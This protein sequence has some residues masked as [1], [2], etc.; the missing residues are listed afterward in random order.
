MNEA[1][2]HI[3]QAG[4][5]WTVKLYRGAFPG[6]AEQ[7]LAS[8][9][10]LKSDLTGRGVTLAAALQAVRETEG[11]AKLFSNI[12]QR[13]F[14]V[15]EKAQVVDAWVQEK[16]AAPEGLLTYFLIDES[17][18]QWPWELLSKSRGPGLREYA[19]A[20]RRHPCVR[21]YATHIPVLPANDGTLRVLLIAGEEVLDPP[22]VK[23]CSELH[24]IQRVF[25][26]SDWSVVVH[27]AKWPATQLALEAEIRRVCPHI[28]H[29]IGHGAS[30]AEDRFA[31]KFAGWE[32]SSAA[33]DRFFAG[34]DWKPRLF[35]I[36]ACHG[37]QLDEKRAVAAVTE[38]LLTAGVP[39]V[40]GSQAT[41]RVD[42]SRN[43]A[44]A[45][46]RTLCQTE[47]VGTAMAVARESIAAVK[48]GDGYARRHW[49][50]PV[51]TLACT[52]EQ[53]L[54]F[55]KYSG[56]MA[57]CTVLSLV[58]KRRGHFIDRT[59][60]RCDVLRAFRP[61]SRMEQ[62]A[63][64]CI[65]E[66]ESE[67]GKSWLAIRTLRDLANAGFQIRYATLSEPAPKRTSL[68]VLEDWRGRA[69]QA[70]LALRKMPHPEFD[71]FDE[72]LKE[73]RDTGDQAAIE[74]AFTAFK[75]AAAAAGAEK[76]VLLVL[77]QFRTLDK[78][79]V[80]PE[81]FRQLV[82]EHLLKP[83]HDRAPD[84][85]N[86]NALLI[87][88]ATPGQND[89]DAYGLAQLPDF[90]R[91]PVP[92]FEKKEVDDLFAE[93]SQFLEYARAQAGGADNII[94]IKDALKILI[95]SDTWPPARLR[96]IDPFLRAV[97]VVE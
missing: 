23:A 17:L 16:A 75:K 18:A 33:M 2:I 71:V 30:P 21:R 69:N 73:A 40:I 88:R 3:E 92:A 59:G 77:D 66:G 12:G 53:F 78:A 46:Y 86:V 15:L 76:P 10:F 67:V 29:F 38:A 31:L 48:D 70:S 36:N 19:F 26:E 35:F 60:P 8:G 37:G 11:E 49:A 89:Y 6:P 42:H 57:D 85:D 4:A 82:L 74:R 90:K 61:F 13:L 39:A 87:V 20:A 22:H 68:D 47:R 93:Y 56:E 64:G 27:A 34:E 52:P 28:I 84:V 97:G 79:T 54:P 83:I 1:L 9:S 55:S 14:D 81:T 58:A 96:D 65:I 62:P 50:V 41:L 80:D 91:I 5:G 43:F 25:Q 51:M 94:K 45:F 32:W 7:P 24:A 95:T 44:V 72:R 63:R